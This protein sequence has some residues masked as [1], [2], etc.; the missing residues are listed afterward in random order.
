MEKFFSQKVKKRVNAILDNAEH[1]AVDEHPAPY[2]H[3]SSAHVHLGQDAVFNTTEQ[4]GDMDIS[5]G[6][7]SV[8][9]NV[10]FSPSLKKCKIQIG[11]GC[12][13]HALDVRS[14]V[15]ESRDISIVIGNNC[16]LHNVSVCVH[17]NGVALKIG[18]GFRSYAATLT[19]NSDILIGDR[20]FISGIG[21][22]GRY[23]RP[24]KQDSVRI[25]DDTFIG[26]VQ[27]LGSTWPIAAS[28]S[29]LSLHGDIG[30]RNTIFM[31]RSSLNSTGDDVTV[32]LR[33]VSCFGRYVL[34]DGATLISTNEYGWGASTDRTLTIG[35][36]AICTLSMPSYVDNIVV[37]ANAV[38][39]L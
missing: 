4:I 35:K 12:W 13:L 38:V 17:A 7:H 21:I 22:V 26:S 3:K 36:N 1:A 20:V 5:I 10:Y 34:Y 28:A 18:D 2:E 29:Q 33:G 19:L 23:I 16:R 14:S 8:V 15:N 6:D 39:A 30:K 24:E 25:G 37:H 27:C 11:D 32:V 9:S 31:D